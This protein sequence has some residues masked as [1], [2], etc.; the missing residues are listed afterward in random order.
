M[1]HELN[2]IFETFYI[3]KRSESEYKDKKATIRQIATI[4]PTPFPCVL[5]GENWYVGNYEPQI[6]SRIKSKAEAVETK[7][8]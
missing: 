6:K 1:N 7:L 8:L 3:C 4:R 5:D 2:K